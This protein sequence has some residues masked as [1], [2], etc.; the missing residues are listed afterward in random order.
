[1][2]VLVILICLWYVHGVLRGART[3]PERVA[4]KDA[5]V[6]ATGLAEHLKAKRPD[7]KAFVIR[8]DFD[9]F[10]EMTARALAKEANGVLVVAEG[11]VGHEDVQWRD[12]GE[13]QAPTMTVAPEA[14]NRVMASAP[15][16]DTVISFVGLPADATRP[17]GTSFLDS[18]ERKREWVLVCCGTGDL[19]KEHLHGKVAAA[20]TRR[21]R[22]RAGGVQ[23]D[24]PGAPGSPAEAFDREFILIHADNVDDLADEY[25]HLLN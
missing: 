18:P 5:H 25:G 13:G 6:L 23:A 19:R 4:G 1:V 7:A 2:A 8:G 24:A 22:R 3:D 17:A 12:S 15:P 14:F 9:A 16:C 11:T 21:P 20:V 10:A